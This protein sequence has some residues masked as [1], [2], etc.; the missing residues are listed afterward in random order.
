ML[1]SY[2]LKSDESASTST[3]E[4]ID[5]AREVKFTNEL[6]ELWREGWGLSLSQSTQLPLDCEQGELAPLSLSHAIMSHGAKPDFSLSQSES[7]WVSGRERV[8]HAIACSV[9]STTWAPA[10]TYVNNSVTSRAQFVDAGRLGT[11]CMVQCSLPGASG[12]SDGVGGVTSDGIALSSM[13]V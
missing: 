11:R 8:S 4:L 10:S 6:I 13:T 5:E 1:F 7:G 9:T 2:W 3:N 12:R